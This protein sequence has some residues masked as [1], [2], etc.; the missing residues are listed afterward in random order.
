M[1]HNHKKAQMKK[2]VLPSSSPHQS[3]LAAIT[4]PPISRA[5]SE[6]GRKREVQPARRNSLDQR[7]SP[8]NGRTA[9]PRQPESAPR[10]ENQLNAE[11]ILAALTSLK[12]G[13][14]KVRLPLGW[15]GI[16]G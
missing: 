10:Y 9:E 7:R 15:T 14:F 2:D 4:T 16:A 3:N 12:K 11:Q 8:T 5:S 1:Q 6:V 13:D